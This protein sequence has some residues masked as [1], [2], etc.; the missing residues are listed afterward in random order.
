VEFRVKI[1][2]GHIQRLCNAFILTLSNMSAKRK[3]EV[4]FGKF[5]EVGICTTDNYAHKWVVHQF[6]N[7]EFILTSCQAHHAVEEKWVSFKF[8]RELLTFL[9]FRENFQLVT[10]SSHCFVFVL[11]LSFFLCF[12]ICVLSAY[13]VGNYRNRMQSSMEWRKKITETA[14]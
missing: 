4:I 10:T 1:C 2:R 6:Y 13:D 9:S 8:F 5:N 7:Y 12:F 14:K 11:F 3:C